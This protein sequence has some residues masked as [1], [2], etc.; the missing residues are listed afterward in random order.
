MYLFLICEQIHFRSRHLPAGPDG[1]ITNWCRCR[2]LNPWRKGKTT[3]RLAISLYTYTASW[4]R[5]GRN[6]SWNSETL[7]VI[8]TYISLTVFY[9][10]LVRSSK[11]PVIVID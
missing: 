10:L 7:I 11:P 5:L 8:S 3:L 9:T 1:I 4:R 6:A 2:R